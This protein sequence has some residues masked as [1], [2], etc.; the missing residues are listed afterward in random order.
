VRV[1]D[2]GTGGAGVCGGF[3][4]HGVKVSF[5]ARAGTTYLIAYDGNDGPFHLTVH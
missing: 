5:P 4:T 1:T 2:A 3:E